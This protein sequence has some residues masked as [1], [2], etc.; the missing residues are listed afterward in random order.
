[1]GEVEGDFGSSVCGGGDFDLGGEVGDFSGDVELRDVE[2]GNARGVPG[3]QASRAPDAAGDEA[4]S[5]IPAIFEGGF[6]EVG[7]LGDVGLLSPFIRGGNFGGGLDGRRENDVKLV[8]ARLQERLHGDA[9]LAEHIVGGEDELVVQ[10]DFG[11]GVEALEDKI[12]I[13]AAEQIGRRLEGGAIFP[14]GI[15]NPLEL[16]FVVAIVGIGDEVVVKQVKVDA[17]GNLRGTPDRVFG[18]SGGGELTEFPARIE[19]ND[20]LLERSLGESENGKEEHEQQS[21]TEAIKA[22]VGLRSMAREPWLKGQSWRTTFQCT[23]NCATYQRGGI[24]K[25]RRGTAANGTLREAKRVFE[26]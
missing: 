4:R 13:L 8:R 7:F 6:A 1:M 3:F 20:L 18:C 25:S 16:G 24:K 9:P 19:R 2:V 26:G 5:P 15:L 17:A 22:H 11:I 12:N 10:I 23:A 21:K 14:V